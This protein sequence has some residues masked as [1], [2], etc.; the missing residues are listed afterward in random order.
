MTD[1]NYLQITDT[2]EKTSSADGDMLINKKSLTEIMPLNEIL[3]GKES[4]TE[5]DYN[6]IVDSLE[7]PNEIPIVGK[8]E[9]VKIWS[10]RKYE[11]NSIIRKSDKILILVIGKNGQDYVGSK[12]TSNTDAGTQIQSFLNRLI[13]TKLIE[14]FQQNSSFPALEKN[15]IEIECKFVREPKHLHYSIDPEKYFLVSI[16]DCCDEEDD[17][18]DVLCEVFS[19]CSVP[20]LHNFSH[21][22]SERIKQMDSESQKSMARM[23]S[24]VDKPTNLEDQLQILFSNLFIFFDKDLDNLPEFCRQTMLQL[25]YLYDDPNSSLEN[26]IKRLRKSVNLISI[27]E[28]DFSCEVREQRKLHKQAID[29]VDSRVKPRSMKKHGHHIRTGKD[30]WYQECIDDLA[31]AYSDVE[32]KEDVESLCGIILKSKDELKTINSNWQIFDSQPIDYYI[33][34]WREVVKGGLSHD[35]IKERVYS[36]GGKGHHTSRNVYGHE[37]FGVELSSRIFNLEHL[38]KLGNSG[39]PAKNLHP[40]FWKLNRLI[41]QLAD[42]HG[43]Y[44]GLLPLQGLDSNLKSLFKKISNDHVVQWFSKIL[45]SENLLKLKI[46]GGWVA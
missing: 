31:S 24:L 46:E 20:I 11:S 12:L 34:K 28:T 10:H 6:S 30:A 45:L 22:F 42:L 38:E 44:V 35:E 13:G 39:R 15:A 23:M 33:T 29:L 21:P 14:E 27:G 40:K 16:I 17:F 26:R 4:P 18:G 41:Y 9:A 37:A 7:T 19:G 32:L 2:S 25:H 43:G 5:D 1:S 8:D 36:K 3:F